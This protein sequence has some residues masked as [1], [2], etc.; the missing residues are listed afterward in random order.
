[1][2][3]SKNL[4]TTKIKD[5]VSHIK[6]YL[7]QDIC[8][9]SQ[10]MSNGTIGTCGERFTTKEEGIQFIQDYKDKWEYGSNDTR[11]EKRDQKI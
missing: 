4:F 1:M 3:K 9:Y 6:N 7:T 2:T 11:Q 10:P 8:K 5:L